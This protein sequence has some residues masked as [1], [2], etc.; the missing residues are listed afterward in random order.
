MEV[1]LHRV[2]LHAELSREPG[3][4][5]FSAFMHQ[6]DLGGSYMLLLLLL[7]LSEL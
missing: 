3:M 2:C 6:P 7:E 5:G 4:V 1:C